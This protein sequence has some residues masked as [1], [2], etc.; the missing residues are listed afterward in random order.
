MASTGRCCADSCHGAAACGGGGEGGGVC[1]PATDLLQLWRGIFERN[2]GAA[3]CDGLCHVYDCIRMQP[4][5]E[6][7]AY[8]TSAGLFYSQQSVL[9]YPGGVDDDSWGTG[10]GDG[11]YDLPRVYEDRLVS[12]CRRHHAS[13]GQKIYLRTQ[14]VR[15]ENAGGIRLLYRVGPG[16]DGSPRIGGLHQQME[17]GEG[18][19]GERECDGVF[20]SRMPF[21]LRFADRDL[22]DVDRDPGLFPGKGI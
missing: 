13:D 8:Q 16:I 11:P 14:R 1:H 18:G 17:S 21:D 3:D 10:G 9:H 12:L 22:Y 19:G 5:C 4:G 20:R 7:A 2:V 15:P 6:R